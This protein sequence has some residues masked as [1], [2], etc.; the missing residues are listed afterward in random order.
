MAME[1]VLTVPD[2]RVIRDELQRLVLADLLGPLGGPEEEFPTREDPLDRYVVGRL[3]P[4]GVSVDPDTQDELSEAAAP[5]ILE[6][7]AEP[8]A[9][10][11]PS[12]TP[13]ALGF[14]ACVGADVT[15]LR[16]TGKWARYERVTSQ[17]EE[18]AGK[19]V[20]RRQPQ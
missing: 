5:D 4:N 3:A 12:L 16:I 6:G 15:A 10:N 7:D 17:H 13:S 2:E 20:W 1:G 19:R 18:H 9:P 14:T 11:V 8:S